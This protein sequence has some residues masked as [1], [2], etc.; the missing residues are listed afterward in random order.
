MNISRSP[1]EQHTRGGSHPD[2]SKLN[3]E[4]TGIPQQITFRKRK[5]PEMD[6]FKTDFADFR[7]EIM[8][9]L[10]GFVETQKAILNKISDDVSVIK[11]EIKNLQLTTKE[12]VSE[13]NY[14]KSD[15]V[16]LKLACA[17]T[18][19]KVDNMEIDL[20]NLKIAPPVLVKSDSLTCED[21]VSELHE[22]ERRSKNIIIVGI[23][24]VKCNSKEERAASDN[25]EVNKI[26]KT[27]L[28]DCPEPIKIH[29][30]G[31]FKPEKV[32]PIKVYLPSQENVKKILRNKSVY[33][34]E[35][36]KIY[37]DQTV[38]QQTFMRKLTEELQHRTQNGEKD[39]VIKYVNN[40]PTIIINKPSKN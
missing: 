40:T 27:V 26:I 33:K 5:Q 38:Y 20:K 23:P 22:R 12:L 34:N 19:T 10:N 36:V 17:A 3:N 35:N 28:P 21:V 4:E 37:S 30:L 14:I 6:D 18:N 32:R 16:D 31:Y 25:R 2:L 9:T 7:K 8:N 1:A 15:I 39:L 24:E 11:D 13:Q 29:R